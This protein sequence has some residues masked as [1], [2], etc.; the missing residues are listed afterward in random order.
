MKKPT[1]KFKNK[2]FFKRPAFIVLKVEIN[3]V[4]V[5]LT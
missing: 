2:I 4:D 5:T 3:F 1:V